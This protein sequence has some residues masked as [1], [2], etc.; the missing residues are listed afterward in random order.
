MPTSVYILDA[1]LFQVYSNR[2]SYSHAIRFA[3]ARKMLGAV[4]NLF[5]E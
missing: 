4:T 1:P 5:Q 3:R 2:Y